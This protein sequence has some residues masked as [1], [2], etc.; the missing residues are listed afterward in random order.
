MGLRR[1]AIDEM[2]QKAIAEME[3]WRKRIRRK[4]ETEK[5]TESAEERL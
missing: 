2:V 3:D 1:P 5:D 4:T